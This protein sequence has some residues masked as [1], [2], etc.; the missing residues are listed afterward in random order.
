MVHCERRAVAVINQGTSGGHDPE[1]H[2]FDI[3][4]GAKSVNYSAWKSVASAEGEGVDYTAL[5]MNGGAYERK[6]E[7]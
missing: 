4:L 6:R 7:I 2:T 5:E 1:L 3:V